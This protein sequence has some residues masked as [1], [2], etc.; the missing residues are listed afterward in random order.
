MT[1]A[2]LHPLTEK[3]LSG[4]APAAV[5]E[6][7]ARGA[8]P[9]PPE[10][11]LRLRV[12]LARAGAGNAAELSRAAL[13]EQPAE[14]LVPVLARPDCPAEVLDYVTRER[15]EDEQVLAAAVQNPATSDGAILDAVARAGGSALEQIVDNQ[16]RLLRTP[17]LVKALDAHPGVTGISRSRLHDVK[18]ELARRERRRTGAP[19]PAV[20]KPGAQAPGTPAGP[21]AEEPTPAPAAAPSDAEALQEGDAAGEPAEGAAAE[22]PPVDEDSDVFIRIMNMKVPEKVELAVKG[23]REERAI[24]VR[25]PIKAVALAVLKSPKLTEP[26]VESIAAMR[27]VVEDVIRIISE[28]REWTKNYAVIHALCKNPKTPARKAMT[29]MT[30]L[31]NRD[32]K[33]LGGDRSVSEIVRNNARRFYVARTQPKV[34]NYRKK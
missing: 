1:A 8:V 20:G 34:N 7:A 5:C 21:A 12:H 15:A 11:L 3:I 24:L 33:L 23:N 9:V 17:D 18:E 29:L 10:E 16:V 4:E 25:D 28:N 22:A 19:V 13:K 31:N 27:N 6:A 14:D 30:R 32:L 2:T 26:E